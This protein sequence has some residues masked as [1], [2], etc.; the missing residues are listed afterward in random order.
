MATDELAT[1]TTSI[2]T[3]ATPQIITKHPLLNIKILPRG[4]DPLPRSPAEVHPLP[5][6]PGLDA[7]EEQES[8]DEDDPPLPADARVLE[9]GV[10]DDGDVQRREQRHEAEQHGPEEEPVPPHVEHPLGEV[11]LAVGLHAEEGPPRVHQ[12]PGQEE[13]EPGQTREGG[14]AG[15]E[16]GVAARRVRVV[17]VLAQLAVAPRPGVHAQREAGQAQRRDPDAVDRRVD[18]ELGREDARLEAPRRAAHDVR[19]GALEAEAHVRQARGDHDDPDDLDGAQGEDGQGRA[20]LEGEADEQR[21]RLRH[22][23]G[24]HVQH[25]LLDV[26][27]DAPALGDGRH[28]GGEVVV[29][30][31]HVRRVFCYV[32]ARLA[33]CYADVGAAEGGRVVHAVAGL[34]G[35]G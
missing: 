6:L 28:D 21:A 34:W 31:D 26:V 4:P 3:T 35:G 17:A 1:A 20:V 8:S 29:G 2:I 32:R 18:A 5:P 33:H 13:R 10:V 19:R 27:E 22:V 7:E 16:H 25:E 23:L 11:L 12:L 24:Q 15:A 30:K 9:H 14:G